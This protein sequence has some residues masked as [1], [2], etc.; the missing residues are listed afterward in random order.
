MGGWGRVRF[1]LVVHFYVDRFDGGLI[2]D[3][4]PC[5]LKPMKFFDARFGGFE[6]GMKLHVV[7]GNLTRRPSESGTFETL[8]STSRKRLSRE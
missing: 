8:T 4:I 3:E 7:V 2:A 6:C 5:R 1:G